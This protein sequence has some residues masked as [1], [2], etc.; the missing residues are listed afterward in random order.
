MASTQEGGEKPLNASEKAYLKDNFGDEFHFLRDHELKIYKEEDRSEGRAI[1]RAFQ[2]YDTLPEED[3]SPSGDNEAAPE[4]PQENHFRADN[5]AEE[6]QY[7]HQTPRAFAPAP[8]FDYVGSLIDGSAQDPALVSAPGGGE[9]HQG[10]AREY[11]MNPNQFGY[12]HE[13]SGAFDGGYQGG[14]QGG[15]QDGYHCGRD[16]GHVGGYSSRQENGRHNPFEGGPN[17]RQGFLD[18]CSDWYV[19]Q[20]GSWNDGCDDLHD[21]GYEDVYDYGHDDSY[22]YVHDDVYDS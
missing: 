17:F 14:F 8:G 11:D 10:P 6:T 22:D 2:K 4:L 13:Q 7:Q 9:Q 19:E 15:R 18:E 3:C 5:R 12:N 16:G 20:Y 21:A 1:L